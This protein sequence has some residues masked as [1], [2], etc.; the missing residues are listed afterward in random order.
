MTAED[1]R[2]VVGGMV[3]AWN[4]RDLDGYVSQLT[5]DVVW[6]DPAMVEPAEGREA[7]RAFSETVLRA[8]PDFRYTI[9]PPICVADDGSRC[10]VPWKSEEAILRSQM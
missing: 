2:S 10:A 6:N 7:V 4:D 3:E 9:R 5:E 1:I 8:F